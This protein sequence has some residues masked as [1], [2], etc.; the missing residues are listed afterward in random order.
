[1]IQYVFYRGQQKISTGYYVNRDSRPHHKKEQRYFK[2][3]ILKVI[4]EKSFQ[5]PMSQE[6]K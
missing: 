2:N 4:N 5:K 6:D 3:P 1:M